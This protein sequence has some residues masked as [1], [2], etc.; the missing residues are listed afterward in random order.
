MSP[1]VYRIWMFLINFSGDNKLRK[2]PFKKSWTVSESFC[3]F[4][5]HSKHFFGNQKCVF[6]YFTVNRVV[7]RLLPLLVMG[8]SEKIKI[9]KIL[10]IS[11]KISRNNFR[12][13]PGDRGPRAWSLWSCW[14]SSVW[15]VFAFG[16]INMQKTFRDF[17]ENFAK[18]FSLYIPGDRGPRAWSW[19]S[20]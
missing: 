14:P 8:I 13:I 16:K 4:S 15:T 12:S 20:Y 9:Q 18:Q 2:N 3:K 19:W 10:Q 6:D 1:H 11:A 17:R 7:H 5:V